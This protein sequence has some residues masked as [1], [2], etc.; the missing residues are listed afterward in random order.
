MDKQRAHIVSVHVNFLTKR[1]ILKGTGGISKAGQRIFFLILFQKQNAYVW[2]VLGCQKKV[3]SIS[4]HVSV[5]VR[6]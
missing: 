5:C 1:E 4:A 2:K 3:I 6:G